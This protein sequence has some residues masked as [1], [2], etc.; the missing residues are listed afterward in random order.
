MDY[1]VHGILQA[2]R[3]LEWVASLLQ[4][5]F[6]TQELNPGLSHCRQIL[7]QLSHK[8]SPRILECIVYPFSN[9]SSWPRNWTRVPC[10]AGGFFTNWAIREAP[11]SP[12]YQNP[13]V[14]VEVWTGL[15]HLHSPDG[16]N[17]TSLSQGCV[18]GQLLTWVTQT[19][20]TFQGQNR[21]EQPLII[22]VQ[23]LGQWAVISSKRLSPT[24]I[25]HVRSASTYTILEVLKPVFICLALFF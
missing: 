15:S 25:N 5:T 12:T 8:G 14:Y 6:P 3:I 23:I 19:E 24:L 20:G 11:P 7:Y 1:T 10:I 22:Q 21:I 18:L 17:T 16:L 13:K 4:G 9:G 2:R